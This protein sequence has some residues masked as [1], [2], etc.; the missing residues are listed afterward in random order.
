MEKPLYKVGDI[1]IW[2]ADTENE[3]YRIT[4]VNKDSYNLKM[5]STG[6]IYKHH[7]FSYTHGIVRKLTKLEKALK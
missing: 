4:K 3:R 2:N 1:L 6:E 5:L 7:E